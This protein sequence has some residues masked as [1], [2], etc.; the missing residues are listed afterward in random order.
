MH[1]DL[2]NFPFALAMLPF[3]AGGIGLPATFLDWR[4]RL[5][6][7]ED[8]WDLAGGAAAIIAWE[9]V[10]LWVLRW[11]KKRGHDRPLGRA[12]VSWYWTP[13]VIFMV[14]LVVG[15]LFVK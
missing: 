13:P 7:S 15:F 2:K 6:Q 3:L 12:V 5:L 8:Y 1:I 11:R 9:W 14:G 10:I 4:H